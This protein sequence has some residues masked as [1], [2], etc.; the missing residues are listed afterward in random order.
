MWAAVQKGCLHDLGAIVLRQKSPK[1]YQLTIPPPLLSCSP[2]KTCLSAPKW[3]IA[4]CW[5]CAIIMTNGCYGLRCPEQTPKWKAFIFLMAIPSPLPV[6]WI[7]MSDWATDSE[8][9]VREGQ[10]DLMAVLVISMVIRPKKRCSCSHPALSL[11][12]PRVSPYKE[13]GLR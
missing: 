7:L 4:G 10:N 2:S 8:L 11:V 1:G 3:E 12:G 5:S 9:V 6:H 13:W